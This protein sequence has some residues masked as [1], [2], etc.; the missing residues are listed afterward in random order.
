VWWGGDEKWKNNRNE[1]KIMRKLRKQKKGKEKELKGRMENV[2]TERDIG[3]KLKERVITFCG[4][5]GER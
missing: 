5:S 2:T 1:N 4:S 3:R